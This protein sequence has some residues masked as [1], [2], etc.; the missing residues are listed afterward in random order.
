MSTEGIFTLRGNTVRLTA[1]PGLPGRAVQMSV[2][3]G[4]PQASD[5]TITNLGP[6]LAFVG[7]GPDRDTAVTNAQEPTTGDPRFCVL[8]YP[9]QLAIE[10]RHGAWFAASTIAGTSELLIS[11]GHGLVHGFSSPN[12]QANA[13]IETLQ[14]QQL[15]ALELILTEL[16]VLTLL[17][18]EGFILPGELDDLRSDMKSDPQPQ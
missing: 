17:T 14:Q 18:K 9:G 6:V 3:T 11:P 5:Y 4:M 15:D 16:Q 1:S 12:S 8:V 7:W 13:Q 10:A 2:I